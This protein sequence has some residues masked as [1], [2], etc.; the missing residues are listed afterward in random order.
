MRSLKRKVKRIFR[1]VLMLLATGLLA[2]PSGFWGWLEPTARAATFTVTNTANTGAGSLRQ[3]II[4]ANN[5]P[6]V[7]TIQFNITGG[8]FQT[9]APTSALTAIADPVIL[10]GTTQPGYSGT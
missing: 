6:G 9:I 3:A 1:A 4:D 10:D 8:G 5:S 2:W 7:D